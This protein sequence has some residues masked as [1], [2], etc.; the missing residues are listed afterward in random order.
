M[1]SIEKNKK[2]YC[3]SYLKYIII[4][5]FLL[6][7]VIHAF[8]QEISSPQY[9]RIV[10]FQS[11]QH[12]HHTTLFHLSSFRQRNT[13]NSSYDNNAFHFPIFPHFSISDAYI[14]SHTFYMFSHINSGTINKLFKDYFCQRIVSI[15]SYKAVQIRLPF[16]L[17]KL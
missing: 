5:V 3:Y 10:G 2:V 12:F 8:I 13:T 11:I 7:F 1:L 6:T 15:D 4:T 14:S 17:K 16:I 9:L